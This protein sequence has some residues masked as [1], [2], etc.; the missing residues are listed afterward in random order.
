VAALGLALAGAV[1]AG[2]SSTPLIDAVKAGDRPAVRRLLQRH[3]DV[4]EPETD[5]TTALPWAV[6]ADA[7][8]VV[9]LVLA[10]GAKPEAVDRYGGR[11]R[12]LAVT[13]RQARRWC[14]VLPDAGARPETAKP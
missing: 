13:K 2:G 6:R 1:R 10:N 12:A 3:V 9:T 8:E 14:A 4:K 5:G 7:R 11:P